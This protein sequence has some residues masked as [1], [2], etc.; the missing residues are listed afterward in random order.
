M[1]NKIQEPDVT[2]LSEQEYSIKPFQHLYVSDPYYESKAN[3]KNITLNKDFPKSNRTAGLVV[4]KLYLKYP[5]NFA[6]ELYKVIAY[7]IRNDYPIAEK[8]LSAHKNG[9]YAPDF[10][11]EKKDLGCDTAQYNIM[12]NNDRSVNIETGAD[13]SYGEFSHYKDN[14]AFILELFISDYE[15]VEQQLQ[16]LAYVFDCKDLLN[17]LLLKEPEKPSDKTFEL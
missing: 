6:F 14:A 9:G 15:P 17:E 4:Q 11:K 1:A 2:I 3:T 12:V 13:G 7:S 5:D 8:F 16:K 10:L